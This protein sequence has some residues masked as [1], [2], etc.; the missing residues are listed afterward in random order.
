[1]YYII[2]FASIMRLIKTAVL[3]LLICFVSCETFNSVLSVNT[4][5]SKS[6]SIKQT[7]LKPPAP[8]T[9]SFEDD[10][11]T[12]IIW[13][14]YFNPPEDMINDASILQRDSIGRYLIESGIYK[15]DAKS[16]C[17]KPGTYGPSTGDGYLYAPLRGPQANIIQKI[18]QKTYNDPSINQKEIQVLLWAIIAQSRFEDLPQ[19]QKQIV[20][21]CL[22]FIEIQQ[23]NG[24]A[25][26]LVPQEVKDQML[27]NTN[28]QIKKVLD[29][30]NNIRNSIVLNQSYQAIES[31]AVLSGPIL[32][33]D[34]IR[35]TP[36]GRWCYHPDGY[37]IRLFPRNYSQTRV[38][39][40]IPPTV[41]YSQ[42]GLKAINEIVLDSLL[43][44]TFVD[45][46]DTIKGLPIQTEIKI[47]SL[48]T[49]EITSYKISGNDIKKFQKS[50]VVTCLKQKFR[51]DVPIEIEKTLNTIYAFKNMY[52]SNK[53]SFVFLLNQAEISLF[54]NTIKK[55]DK[56]RFHKFKLKESI[57]KINNFQNP[58]GIPRKS[59]NDIIKVDL[60]Q[61]IAAPSI[62]S[63]Q[64]I[65]QAPGGSNTQKSIYSVKFHAYGPG[66]FCNNN[67]S[68]Y[69]HV[70]V[71]FLID[72][73]REMIR[74]AY[75]DSIWY[76]FFLGG[77]RNIDDVS[78]AK[79]SW[80]VQLTEAEYRRA[81]DVKFYLYTGV[82]LNCIW[83]ADDVAD[84]AGL[85]TPSLISTVPNL[86][87]LLNISPVEYV[88]NLKSMN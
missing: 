48:I 74:G 43:R 15:I 76:Q 25:W 12:E 6:L 16:Y 70:F 8:V 83:Y 52:Y 3:A 20:G 27:S 85:N 22:N 5:L 40:F 9:T 13:M 41:S 2:L 63:K 34:T 71:E 21:K 26:D 24:G 84:K 4:S 37:F 54:H 53:S 17:L 80:Q 18:L 75:P 78:C 60:S 49:N 31:I 30:E 1:M 82:G 47:S 10:A 35:S 67:L 19:R 68:M 62:T 23:L 11:L 56:V 28:T 87:Y 44:L 29:I 7:L 36:A 46:I 14:D 59:T 77:I 79:I 50:P 42:L 57:Y 88:Q 66:T 73:K 39:F 64:R 72:N 32:W 45:I 65:L 86:P 61:I 33:G 51:I 58:I 38:E 69:G 55:S 81:A